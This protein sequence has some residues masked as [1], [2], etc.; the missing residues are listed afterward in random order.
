[1]V[2]QSRPP[3]AA[4]RPAAKTIRVGSDFCGLGTFMLA[5]RKINARLQIGKYNVQHCFSS[6]KM[7]AAKRLMMHMDPPDVFYPDVTKRDLETVPV[8]D[9][10]SLTAPCV[11]FSSAGKSEG[12]SDEKGIG[13]LMLNSMCYIAQ[14]LPKA[15]VAEN[16][17]SIQ[18]PKHRHF[19][20]PSFIPC[21]IY[22][23]LI[24]QHPK[25][26]TPTCRPPH[27]SPD[28]Q[29]LFT[30]TPPLKN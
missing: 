1:M 7:R 29:S 4:A 25:T 28:R 10:Y 23:N 21:I 27:P 13:T 5:M 20:A 8:T 14:Y 17:A 19:I 22:F 2:K 24:C 9:L 11:T 18:S 15:V 30:P 6:D 26:R 12:V 3:G 16:V